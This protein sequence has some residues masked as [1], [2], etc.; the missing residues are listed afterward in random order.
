MS[1]RNTWR[2]CFLVPRLACSLED[3]SGPHGCFAYLVHWFV[4]L[5]TFINGKL[6]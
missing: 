3:I 1:I 5:L 4:W 2:E 6:R